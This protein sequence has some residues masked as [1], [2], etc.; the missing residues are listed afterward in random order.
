MAILVRASFPQMREFEDRFISLGL[1]YRVVGDPRF[2]ERAEIRDALASLRL[3]AQP[4]D[5]LAF[6]RIVNKLTM[7]SATRAC[8]ASTNTRAASRHARLL[9]APPPCRYRRCRPRRAR[10]WP[11]L[12]INFPLERDGA[13]VPHATEI[14]EMVLGERL[15]RHAESRQISRGAQ[16]DE[17]LK[18]FVRSMEVASS[19]S[20][21]SSS[22][23]RW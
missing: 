1:P 6:E 11:N 3:V 9:R 14:A 19:R 22:T 5:D 2:Y 17:N 7:T 15:H 13:A 20:L 10:R 12:S 18:E 8:K 16:A 23:S 4:D 21:R